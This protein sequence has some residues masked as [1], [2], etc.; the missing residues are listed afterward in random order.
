MSFFRPGNLSQLSLENHGKWLKTILMT[1]KS[2]KYH[3]RSFVFTFLWKEIITGLGKHQRSFLERNLIFTHKQKGMGPGLRD[4]KY[5]RWEESAPTYFGSE[6]A[7]F[8]PWVSTAH[9][10]TSWVNLCCVM[11]K[12]SPVVHFDFRQSVLS[13]SEM[14]RI[15]AL[16]GSH[17][18]QS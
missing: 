5:L 11:C 10:K 9:L 6:R 1:T 14:V 7:S 15:S 4:V 17:V 2:R 12:T 13:A 3:D 16:Y 18:H 8:V